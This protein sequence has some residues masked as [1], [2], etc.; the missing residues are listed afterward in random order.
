MTK[1]LFL[2]LVLVVGCAAWAEASTLLWDRN[3]DTDM[4]DYQVW[5]CFTPSCVVIKSPTTLQPGTVNQPVSGITPGYVIDLAG[6]E[7]SLA[8][9][10]RD[11][12]LNESAL[13]VP[14]PFDF[15]GPVA[16]L[17]PRLTP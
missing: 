2:V 8:V 16:P 17:N 7:G 1:T 11:L 14:V 4:K 12:S 13:S 5:A 9:S 6:K 10:A 3:T 15:R